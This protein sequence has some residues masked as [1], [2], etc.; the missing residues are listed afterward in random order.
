MGMI[1]EKAINCEGIKGFFS[2]TEVTKAQLGSARASSLQVPGFYKLHMCSL[3][4][5]RPLRLLQGQH[6]EAAAESNRSLVRVC[7]S[8]W[9]LCLP[10]TFQRHV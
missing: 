4:I 5:H 6:G 3:V 7:T 9:E 10:S 1:Q 8:L 2:P